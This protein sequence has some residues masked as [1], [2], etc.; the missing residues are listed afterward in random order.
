MHIFSAPN[1]IFDKNR[2]TCFSVPKT[3]SFSDTVHLY[4]PSFLNALLQLLC[5]FY[6]FKNASGQFEI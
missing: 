2:F 3:H 6:V 1:F 5:L 4:S